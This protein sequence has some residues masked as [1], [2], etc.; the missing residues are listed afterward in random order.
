MTRLEANLKIAE[1]LKKSDDDLFQALGEL[2][3]SASKNYPDQRAGQ[4]ITNYFC[5]DYRS[6]KVSSQTKKIL[7]YMFPI[8]FDPFFEESTETLERMSKMD[9]SKTS[10]I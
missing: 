2:F 9:N 4:I 5:G 1:I 6:E 7:E 10:S 3:E 8:N